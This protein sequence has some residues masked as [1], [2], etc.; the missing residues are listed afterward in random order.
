MK[1]SVFKLQVRQLYHFYNMSTW[2]PGGGE[3]GGFAAY[4]SLS[5]WI[6]SAFPFPNAPMHLE[7]LEMRSQNEGSSAAVTHLLS[8]IIFPLKGS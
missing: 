4:N 5:L 3:E 6:T 1:P 2:G 8:R 7:D